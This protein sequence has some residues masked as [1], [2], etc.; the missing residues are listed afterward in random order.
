M[1]SDALNKA[2]YYAATAWEEYIE[3]TLPITAG[4]TVI[5]FREM[6][7]TIIFIRTA[8]II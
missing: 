5:L 1:V 8:E 3:I 6:I 4:G 2:S 7:N